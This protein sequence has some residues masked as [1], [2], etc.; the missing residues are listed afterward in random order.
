MNGARLLVSLLL[1]AVP[2]LVHPLVPR[3]RYPARWAVLIALLLGGGFV[4]LELSLVHASLPLVFELLGLPAMAAACRSL[5]GH[6]LGAPPVFSAFTGMLA[7]GISLGAL[8]SA[9]RVAD[10]QRRLLRCSEAVGSSLTI[11]GIEVVSVPVTDATALAV[12]GSPPTVMVSQGLI[13]SLGAHQLAAVVRHEQAHLRRRHAPLVLLGAAVSGGLAFLPWMRVSERS[14]RL[15]LERWAD[16]EAAVGGED[17]RRQVA[18]ALRKVVELAVGATELLEARLHPGG[19]SGGAAG[20]EVWGWRSVVAGVLPLVVGLAV[21]L[22]I[23]LADVAR[24][25]A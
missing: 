16:D 6:L 8:R 23:H 4:L 7:L 5:G 21:T 2:A 13:S 1:L 9:H 15:A 18:A 19:L 3:A 22:V 12:P 11:G 14:L 20:V 25:A 17:Y 10:A 24:V